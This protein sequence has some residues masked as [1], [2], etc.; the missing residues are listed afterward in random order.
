MRRHLRR[1]AHKNGALKH[2]IVVAVLDFGLSKSGVN[3]L[4]MALLSGADL[5]PT[6][7]EAGVLPVEAALQI[8]ARYVRLSKISTTWV[9]SIGTLNHQTY[10]A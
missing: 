7:N 6:L 1:E 10:G 9:T 4:V 3:Y 2:P 8:A 5:A